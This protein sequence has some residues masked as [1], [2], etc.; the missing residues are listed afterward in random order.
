MPA[1]RN[2]SATRE[3][4]DAD[5]D[6]AADADCREL[7]DAEHAPEIASFAELALELFDRFVARQFGEK[8]HAGPLRR[9]FD[10]SGSPRGHAWRC[11]TARGFVVGSR[12]RG[13]F[14][15]SVVGFSDLRPP[16]RGETIPLPR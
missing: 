2:D 7:P 4:E 13:G 6:N 12:V 11:N 1:M 8:A 10:H 14:S 3:H 9:G 15:Y 16:S 5:A